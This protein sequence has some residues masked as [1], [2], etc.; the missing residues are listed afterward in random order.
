MSRFDRPTI[1]VEG[2]SSGRQN[3]TWQSGGS[4]R[5]SKPSSSSSGGG[6]SYRSSGGGTAAAAAPASSGNAYSSI[7]Q[8][9]YDQQR[10]AAEAAEAAKRAAAQAAYDRGM[11]ALGNA[12]NSMLGN[13][14]EN[15]DS[16]LGTL[17][18]SYDSGV[19]GTNQQADKTMNEAYVNYM[20]TR[21][22][23]PQ[24]LAAQGVNGGAAEST[25]ASL[26]N[27]YGNSRNEIDT[28]R[29]NTLADLLEQLNANRASALQAFNASKSDLEA[30]RM[31]YQM[32][33]ENALA[34]GLT[35]A[36]N[37]KFDALQSIG[38]QYLTQ[39]AQI[40]QEQQAAA[41]A[42]AARS[43]TASNRYTTQNTQ[44]GAGGGTVTPSGGSSSGGGTNYNSLMDGWYSTGATT[45]QVIQNLGAL[46]LTAAQIQQIMGSY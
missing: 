3:I 43:Y 7:L 1:S 46:G 32:E 40:A 6:S 36:A 8:S 44:Q 14:Q 22:D 16:S 31:A 19:R 4:R 2:G 45:N 23:M 42:A 9:W 25:Y 15:Y 29:N 20:L 17:Q 33:L 13:L 34:A 12:Y 41:Q 30:Q 21:R 39:A 35:S 11:A 24:L 10:A 18:D 28:G 38:S 37:T 27:N 26:L 5:P